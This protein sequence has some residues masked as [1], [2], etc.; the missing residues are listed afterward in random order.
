MMIVK[1]KEYT[2]EQSCRLLGIDERDL[3]KRLLGTMRNGERVYRG[4][5]LL[6][7]GSLIAIEKFNKKQME[8]QKN[9]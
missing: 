4:A 3:R 2:E 6:R 1:D 7:V 5:D 8:E 9:G